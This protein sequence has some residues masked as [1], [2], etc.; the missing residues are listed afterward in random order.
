[1]GTLSFA[2]C[3]FTPG[4]RFRYMGFVF[5]QQSYYGCIEMLLNI[6]DKQRQAKSL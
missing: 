2:T 4:A 1:M 6:V 5:I 3:R